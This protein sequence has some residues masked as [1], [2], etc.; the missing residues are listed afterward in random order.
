MRK[1]KLKS[2]SN[3]EEHIKEDKKVKWKSVLNVILIIAITSVSIF[4][5]FILLNYYVMFELN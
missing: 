5:V 4:L 2:N 1:I 3:K